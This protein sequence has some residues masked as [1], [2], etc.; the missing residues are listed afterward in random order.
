MIYAVMNRKGGCAKTTTA[1]AM[2]AGWLEQGKKVLLIDT[3]GQCNLSDTM[4]AAMDGNSLYEV[5]LGNCRAVDAI[6]HTEQGEII[7][8]SESVVGLEAEL[9]GEKTGIILKKA[10]EG[11]AREY[12]KIVIDT[13]PA[14]DVSSVNALAAADVVI[15]PALADGYS[16]Q[17]IGQ[18]Q[19]IIEPVKKSLNPSLRVGGILLTKYSARTVLSRTIKDMAQGMAESL[20]G[21]LFDTTIRESVTVR[22]SQIEQESL[23]EYAP[24]AK[25]TQ[26]YRNFLEEL[27]RRG[28]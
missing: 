15:I 9:Q 22:E 21:V 12:D 26:D 18:L 27:E 2:A 20:G 23:F 13:P 6:Q 5:M 14:V 19:R 8:S 10:L 4:R 1:H 17:G 28:L 25:V 7:P 16:L 11:I 3:D 24:K